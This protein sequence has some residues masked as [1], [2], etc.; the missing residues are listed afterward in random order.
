MS[1]KPH[2]RFV[3]EIYDPE[4]EC[5]A[6]QVDI[7]TNSVHELSDILGLPSMQV[8]ETYELDKTD[9]EKIGEHFNLAI[10]LNA[11]RAVL[12]YRFDFD[13]LPYRIHGNRELALMLAGKKPLAVFVGDYH[14]D[15]DLEEIPEEK[16]F[17]PYVASG[18]FT[19][20]EY[21]ELPTDKSE[22]KTR[23]ILYARPTEA[24]RMNAYLLMIQTARKVGWN[25]G[26]ERMEGALLGYE[27]WQNDAHIQSTRC[28]K[29]RQA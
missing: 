2:L 7:E 6:D 27:E 16:L 19:K 1:E 10:S 20:R 15:L 29:Q 4:T 28:G 12:R 11:E 21:V 23:R 9:L 5:I 17:D 8:H 26:F 3:I 24:W 14:T 22:F 25:E 18:R 13:D